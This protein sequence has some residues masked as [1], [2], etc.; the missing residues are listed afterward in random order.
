MNMINS[1]GP[2][3]N[4]FIFVA[5][6]RN[7][8]NLLVEMA[9]IVPDG[10]VCFFTSYVY[11]VSGIDSLCLVTNIAERS[12]IYT[13]NKEYLFAFVSEIEKRRFK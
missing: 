9:S 10:L 11:M 8:G 5:V 7:Y 3:E 4:E 12:S 13:N 1:R 2:L 6:V